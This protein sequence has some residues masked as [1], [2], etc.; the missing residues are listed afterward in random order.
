[1]LVQP[2]IKNEALSKADDMFRCPAEPLMTQNKIC[3]MF[4]IHRRAAGQEVRRGSETFEC[5]DEL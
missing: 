1:M 5:C 4:N 2:Q 3:E